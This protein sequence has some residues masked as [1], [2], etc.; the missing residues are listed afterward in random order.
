MVFFFCLKEL[1]C[2]EELNSTT[3]NGE[4]YIHYVFKASKT[5]PIKDIK[6]TKNNSELQ[7]PSDK[8]RGGGVADNCITILGPGED[9]K[10]LYTCTIWNA[11]GQVSKSVKLGTIS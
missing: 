11:V 2:L 3:R 5:V 4:I 10:G 1:P 6:W 9:D 7:L 8:Y